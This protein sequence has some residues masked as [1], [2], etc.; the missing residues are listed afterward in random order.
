MD[1]FA[2]SEKENISDDELN[3]LKIYGLSW[4]NADE[5]SIGSALKAGKLLEVKY[6]KKN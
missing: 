2:K 6:E 3:A 4:L 1:G 5:N